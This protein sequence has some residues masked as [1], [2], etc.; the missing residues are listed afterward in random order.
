[1]QKQS[2][3]NVWN[4]RHPGGEGLE[5]GVTLS[6]NKAADENL[7][8]SVREQFFHDDSRVAAMR[9]WRF[10]PCPHE[11]SRHRA[12]YAGLGRV[13]G[14]VEQQG[15]VQRRQPFGIELQQRAAKSI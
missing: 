8:L 11:V 6:H 3:S 4:L 5:H 13:G 12:V 9:A 1:M 7:A 14:N 15:H 2:H 10:R